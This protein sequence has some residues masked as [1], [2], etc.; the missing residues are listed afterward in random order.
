[1]SLIDLEDIKADFSILSRDDAKL[2]EIIE[3]LECCDS[4]DCLILLGR[5]QE[6][7]IRLR[8]NLKSN[9]ECNCQKILSVPQSACSIKFECPSCRIRFFFPAKNF[10]PLT[11]IFPLTKLTLPNS[12]SIL[13]LDFGT[14]SLKSA[15]R[16]S[17]NSTAESLNIGLQADADGLVNEDQSSIPSAIFISKSDNF[18]YFGQEALFRGQKGEPFELFEISPKKWLIELSPEELKKSIVGNLSKK[19]LLSGLIS[20]ALES[21][22]IQGG[23]NIIDLC[24][25]EL[26]VSHPVWPN[27]KS[28]E[29]LNLTLKE[30]TDEALNLAYLRLLNSLN[31]I[32]NLDEF[33]RRVDMGSI[34]H[35]QSKVDVEEPVAAAIELFENERNSREVCVIIDV[36]AGTTDIG[37]FESVTPDND[38]KRKI[39]PL[40]SPVSVYQAG[41]FID[42]ELI[43]TIKEN[44]TVELNSSQLGEINSRRRQ[45]KETLFN[46]GYIVEFGIQVQLNDL[47]KREGIK[48]FCERI[49]QEF[50]K[51]IIDSEDSIYA[52]FNATRNP[53]KEIDVIFSGGGANIGFLNSVIKDTEIE[54]KGHKIPIALRKPNSRKYNNLKAPIERLAVSLG[55]TLDSEQWPETKMGDTPLADPLGYKCP[56]YE[57]YPHQA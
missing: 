52:L 47:V 37:L 36:G 3:K 50:I 14:S 33:E 44:S 22:M 23:F 40:K 9:I 17:Y 7:L 57:Q 15:L 1:M 54:I 25:M 55:G 51:K 16:K 19:N 13:C 5:A 21:S 49:K 11:P 12:D 18:I 32:K 29:T 30:I 42:Q 38:K 41:D 27:D 26:R 10:G 20:V 31:P 48:S 24:A 8:E 28:A 2:V 43:D 35:K 34:N 4:R 39:I 56:T 53:I 46:F 6:C 45:I